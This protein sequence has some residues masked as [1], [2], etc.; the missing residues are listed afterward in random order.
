MSIWENT[1]VILSNLCYPWVHLFWANWVNLLL[2]WNSLSWCIFFLV[3]EG[4]VGSS[5]WSLEHGDF[6]WSSCD[7]GSWLFGLWIS[8][9]VE[10]SSISGIWS[11]KNMNFLGLV[12]DWF[13]TSW[14]LANLSHINHLATLTH[15]ESSSESCIWG[16]DNVD[17]LGLIR[18]WL[19]TC[20]LLLL[21][22]VESSSIS[23]IW[24]LKNMN[25]L[26]LVGDWLITWRLLCHLCHIN[27][28]IIFTHV[29]SRSE[30]CI[31]GLDNVDLLRFVGDWL[32]TCWLAS[33]LFMRLHLVVVEW[34]A[35]HNN[36]L[37]QILVTVHTS[38][39]ELI[40]RDA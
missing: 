37:A 5:D 30:S 3:V 17:L 19:I 14:L 1:R 35:L 7:G 13:I 26:S 8:L 32:I 23:G 40:V 36:V 25:F 31:W 34:L 4:G 22:S 21:L 6:L 39:K 20:W 9:S 24:S 16:L 11:L 12:R 15:V 38:G 27:H 2:L 33:W 10:S 18:N 28:L 29:E